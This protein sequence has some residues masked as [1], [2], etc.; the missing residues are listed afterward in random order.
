MPVP[1]LIAGPTA[2]GKSALAL[3]MAEQHGGAVINADSMQVYCELR[4]LTARPTPEEEA[5]VPHR[6][7]GHVSVRDAYSVGRWLDD[8]ADA[9]AWC[10]GAGRRP[11]IVGGTGLYFKALLEGLAPI[12]PVAPE[13]RAHWRREAGVRAAPELHGVLVK[14]DPAMAARL[15]PGDTQ[16][17]VRAL[18]VIDSTGVSLAE[19]Q[20]RPGTPLV[21]EAEAERYVIR[22][23]REEVRR[24]VDARFDAMMAEGALDEARALAALDLD[25]ELPAARAHGLRPLIAHL[26]GETDLRAAIEAGKLE[27]RQYVKRQEIWLRRNMIA[28]KSIS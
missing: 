17:I 3:E 21:Q 13:I 1:I 6:L 16:R 25:P 23:P 22:R 7:F 26:R 24:R 15:D 27:T 10:A 4:I 28:W 9:L 5:R 8:V 18:E 12:P 11:V 20:R 14:R 19:W 2:S